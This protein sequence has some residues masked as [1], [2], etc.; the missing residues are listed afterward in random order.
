MAK[1][2]TK[3]QKLIDGSLFL[4]EKRKK[5]LRKALKKASDKDKKE[6]VKIL[7]SEDEAI[8]EI[9]ENYINSK[10]KEALSE[11]DRILGKGKLSVS[12]LKEKKEKK[13]EEKKMEKLLEDL[14]NT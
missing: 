2:D 1:T 8:S 14:D 5:K 13:A 10:G 11:L 9:I 3:I 6:L 4:D 12:K 7:E